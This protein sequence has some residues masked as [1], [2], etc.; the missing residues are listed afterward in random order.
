MTLKCLLCGYTGEAD[1]SSDTFPCCSWCLEEARE[2]HPREVSALIKLDQ[3]KPV[4]SIWSAGRREDSLEFSANKSSRSLPVQQPA[5][6]FPGILLY[7]GDMDDACDLQRLKE[8]KIGSV[9]NL[10]PERIAYGYKHIPAQLAQAG[11]NQHILIAE[12][13]TDFDIMQV[14]DHAFGAIQAR[15]AARDENAGVLIHCW[16]GVNRSAA[17]AIAFLTIHCK[18]PLLTAIEN[19]MQ[20]RGTI[21]TNQSF[22]KQLVR[23]CFKSGLQLEGA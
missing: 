6:A 20:Q 10:C 21:L 18:V 12:D 17:V 14:A 3:I 19:A 22:R 11:I 8:L 16:G 1:S 5:T 9:V 23:R 4:F 2:L 7:I 13:S 15:L